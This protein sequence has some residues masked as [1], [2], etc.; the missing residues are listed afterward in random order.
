MKVHGRYE[1]LEDI[2]VKMHNGSSRK[3]ARIFKF[4]HC[5]PFAIPGRYSWKI[6]KI[7][8]YKINLYIPH[9]N[10]NSQFIHRISSGG[11]KTP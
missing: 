1:W 2:S 11:E 8:L 4:I 7:S 10:K 6:H 5:A 3:I 9:I